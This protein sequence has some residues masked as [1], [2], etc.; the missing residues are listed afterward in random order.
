MLKKALIR[1]V[2]ALVMALTMV[3]GSV[4]MVSA[5]DPVNFDGHY[6]QI[7]HSQGITWQEANTLASGMTLQIGQITYEGHLAVITSAGENEFVY[8]QL[9]SPGRAW[10]GASQLSDQASPSTGWQ[11]VTGESMSYINWDT[12]YGSPN[13]K[14][15]IH[16]ITS[17]FEDNGENYMEMRG[18]GR[19]DDVANSVE[20]VNDYVVEF[21]P[22]LA[23]PAIIIEKHTNGEDADTPT[24][25]S[26]VVGDPVLWEYIVTNTGDVDLTNVVVTDDILG[27]I[28]TI[29]SL[30]AGETQTLTANGNA[31]AGQYANLG[32]ATGEYNGTTVSAE[33]PSHYLGVSPSIDIEKHT[34]GEDA[35][36]PTG[37]S[38]VVGDPVLW[39]YIVTNTGD[40][41]LTNV[42]VTDDILG[43]IGTIASLAAGETQ[44]LT[45]NG[46]A[47]AGQ[48]ANLGTAT[49][50]YNGTTVSD[51]DPSHYFGK[52]TIDIKP[53]SNTNS[54]NPDS[55]GVIP[56]AILTTTDFDPSLVDPN[57]LAFGPAGAPAVKFAFEDVDGDGVLD[58]IL[59]FRTQMTGLS[60]GDTEAT[61]IGQ[62]KDGRDIMGTDSVRI[63]PSKGKKS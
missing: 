19:W 3:I 49:G 31:A 23:E 50:E 6:Y 17:G 32:T 9:V 11:W 21:E 27:P 25:L 5:A 53:G 13:D 22:V 63:V 4:S 8:T 35:D 62:T 20:W 18:E 42:V 40:V 46:N 33:D 26:I 61:L 30:A 54:I 41:D 45:A 15:I 24:G 10:I 47:A 2:L 43:P 34:N 52:I 58:M 12:P 38:I 44:T 57:T 28:G 51:E 36:T 59:H 48:Y 7:Y 29:A 14:G 39:E 1:V 56:V 37:L 60:F 16:P 55:K